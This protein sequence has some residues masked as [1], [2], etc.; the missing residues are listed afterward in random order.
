MAKGKKAA[1]IAAPTITAL[2]VVALAAMGT[3]DDV[4]RWLVR[5][6]RPEVWSAIA[7]WL[8]LAVALGAFLYAKQQ[9][10]E[11]RSTRI[12]QENQARDSLEQQAKLSRDALDH[13]ADLSRQSLTQQAEMLQKQIAEQARIAQE[14]L[15]E[16]AKQAQLTRDEIAQP[17]VVMY[18]EPCAV[19]W[20]IQEIVIKN[21]GSTPAFRIT[22]I[23][24]SPL[25]SLP[26]DDDP[27]VDARDIPMPVEIPILAPN[28]AW[29]TMWD[30]ATERKERR[31]ELRREIIQGFPGGPPTGTDIDAL[32]NQRMP[33][34]KHTGKVQYY[35]AKGN[36]YTT[37]SILDF[38]LLDG[39]TRL[40]S[41]GIHDI[42]KKYV[43]DS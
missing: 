41:Y 22:P 4:Y 21:F 8:T 40:R 24:D 25:Q 39:T 33:R 14:S 27:N 38:D 9:V 12:S 1:I 7:A 10:Q 43:Q 16:Q 35:D 36:V 34:S 17:N 5:Y 15:D 28:Q 6:F 23:V 11:A 32:V 13:Q 26:N 3:I 20:Q 29:T 30:D 19:D 2:A 42:A 37:Q 18:T 31:T